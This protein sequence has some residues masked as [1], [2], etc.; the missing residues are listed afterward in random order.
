MSLFRLL[1]AQHHDDCVRVAVRGGTAVLRP[2]LPGD[3]ETLDGVFDGLSAASRIS[4]FMAPLPRLT[5]GM[6]RALVQVD[7]CAHVAW[8]A[9][10]DGRPVGIARYVR[11]EPRTAEVAFEVA[12]AHQG[13]G[14]GA[15]LV[16]AVT[17]VAALNGVRRL[18]ASV[19]P[20][21]ESSLRLLRRI[22]LHLR[23]HAGLLEGEASLVLMSTPRVDRP[24][25]AAVA[26]RHRPGTLMPG[27]LAQ[28][29]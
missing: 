22:G 27:E 4:R 15:A 17:T 11:T 23:P 20:G 7:G 29:G 14:I 25:V 6:R 12:D 21:N 9:Y 16:D 10:V 1:S 5:A 3:T 28:V 18:S 2:L 19:L 13:R 26:L 24:A 8:A